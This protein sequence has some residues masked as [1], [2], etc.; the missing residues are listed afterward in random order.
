LGLLVILSI[1]IITY[2]AITTDQQVL[3][4]IAQGGLAPS[5]LN[6]LLGNLDDAEAGEGGFV[7]TGN[8]S[9][10]QLYSGAVE[11]VNSTEQRVSASVSFDANLT[12]EYQLL[13]PVVSQRLSEL[14]QAVDARQSI[15][16]SAAQEAVSTSA[17]EQHSAEIRSIIGK[18][19]DRI[20]SLQTQQVALANQSN[21]VQLG[22]TFLDSVFALAVITAAGY[23]VGKNLMVEERTR[24]EA[25]LLQDILTHDIRNYNQIQLTNAELLAEKVKG[26]RDLAAPV[27]A[28]VRAVENSTRFVERAQRLG[29]IMSD[30][31]PRLQPVDLLES[32]DRAWLHAKSAYPKKTVERTDKIP[33]KFSAERRAKVWADDLLED[34]FVN[35]FTNAIKFAQG[36]EVPIDI[37]IE[38]WPPESEGKARETWASRTKKY[39]RMAGS[40]SQWRVSIGDYGPGIPEGQRKFLFQRYASSQ[41]T[42]LGMSIVDALV[43]RYGGEILAKDNTDV[44]DPKRTG[45]IFV[46]SLRKA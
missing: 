16:F 21:Q 18:M 19:Q 5:N 46:I 13:L 9:Y 23:M 41:G 42:G 44:A 14:K 24:K 36:K 1:T 43:K 10:L 11:A 30:A 32:I 20:S 33:E 17:G 27:S 12:S 15:G 35:V 28:L 45:T 8:T 25:Q 2:R 22:I 39:L 31:R 26:D 4:D 34:V 37:S 29:W 40:R 7:I 6:Q 3:H 38:S